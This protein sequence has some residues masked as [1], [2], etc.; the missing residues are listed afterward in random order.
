MRVV[1]RVAHGLPWLH[2]AIARICKRRL[3]KPG[4]TLRSS[5]V[6]LYFNCYK[7]A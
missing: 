7:G 3:V 1:L 5:G 4:V 2:V 6:L